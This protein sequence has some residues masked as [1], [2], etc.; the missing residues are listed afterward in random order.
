MFRLLKV[1]GFAAFQF[2]VPK[3]SGV[4]ILCRF[5]GSGFEGL[6]GL[7]LRGLEWRSESFR[8]RGLGRREGLRVLF[9]A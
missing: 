3:P 2:Q 5:V 9:P 8:L 4:A 7:G 6:T 1:W